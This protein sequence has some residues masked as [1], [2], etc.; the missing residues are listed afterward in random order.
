MTGTE[1]FLN[2]I[3]TNSKDTLLLIRELASFV[4]FYERL[5]D[6]LELDTL[7]GLPGSNKYLDF[8][9]GIEKRAAAIGV[10]VFDVN[11]LKYYNDAMG[12]QSGDRLL[13][14][15][16][17]S[18]HFILGPNVHIFRTGGDEFVGIIMNCAE[19]DIDST[20]A[21]WQAKLAELN[22]VNDGIRCT[23]AWGTAFGPERLSDL[24]ALADERMYVEKRRMKESGLR[25]GEMH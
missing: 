2:E 5:L 16:A 25:L 12:H 19:S 9:A 13:Q 8:R 24:L 11:D 23:I 1:E 15:A 20:V 7:T 4:A 10:I 3:S 22:T 18:F 21:K 14:K 6:K 17:E